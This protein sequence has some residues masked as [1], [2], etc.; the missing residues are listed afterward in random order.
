MYYI[1]HTYKRLESEQWLLSGN[2]NIELRKHYR[3]KSGNILR[4]I[5]SEPCFEIMF[6]N[7]DQEAI[8]LIS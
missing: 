6:P 4:V 8:Y 5:C 2:L 3:V 7:I 1:T